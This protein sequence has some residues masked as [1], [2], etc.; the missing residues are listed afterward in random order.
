M[1][2]I[3]QLWVL[4]RSDPNFCVRSIPLVDWRDK[5]AQM[6]GCFDV[7]R[8]LKW[9]ETNGWLLTERLA[10]CLQQDG[11]DPYTHTVPLPLCRPCSINVRS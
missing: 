1:E 3:C 4:N 6:R 5:R 9:K 2:N 11:L 8:S 7:T 10:T